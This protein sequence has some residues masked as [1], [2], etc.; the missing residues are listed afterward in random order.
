MNRITKSIICLIPLLLLFFN[1]PVGLSPKAW[2]MFPFYITAILGIM[3]RPVPDAAV[4]LIVLGIYSAGFNGLTVSLSGF[5]SGTTWLVFS[6]FLIGQAFVGT[7]LG[8]RI[9]YLLIGKFGRTSLGLGYAAAIT[10]L[11]ICP[12]TPSN[13]ARSGGIVY[14]IFRSLS[15]ALGSEPDQSP[16][17]IG[18]YFSLAMYQISLC[19]GIV[20][21][22][23]LASNLLVLNFTK[24]VLGLDVT[25]AQWFKCFSVPG[26]VT[27]ALAPLV[28]YKLYPP[29][30]KV[31]DNKPIAEKGLAE[32]GPMKLQEK[33]LLFFFLLAVIGWA[34]TS[35]TRINA[36]AVALGFVAACL[37]TGVMSWENLSKDRSAW[38]T[39]MWYGGIL[40][41]AGGLSREGFFKWLG[42][43]LSLYINLDGVNPMLV[44]LVLLIVSIV[45]RYLFAS[46]AAYVTS[47]LP[48]LYTLG[49]I[50][51]VEPYLLFLVLSA[52]S[53]FASLLTHY[54][55]AAGPVLYGAGYVNQGSWWKVGTIMMCV[56]IVVYAV[57][58]MPYWKLL[59]LW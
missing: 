28:V 13:T 38:A 21:M 55:N 47:I 11:A 22:T 8:R 7:G 48:V 57:I 15:V 17:R 37:A 29:E 46:L 20:F 43:T 36:T 9:A 49:L 44:L 26:L 12:A 1:A 16:R 25:W 23:G 2:T 4:L 18:A 32:L 33:L 14:P 45:V 52:S 39:L 5:S 31:I 50:G 54:G 24:G 34:T 53:S 41:L 51:K 6:A 40:S 42:E 58:G 56:C 27:L 3:L 59:N 19:S 35:I 10:D 30:L